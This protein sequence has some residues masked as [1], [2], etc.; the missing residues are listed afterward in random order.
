[1]VLRVRGYPVGTPP[2]T[3]APLDESCN[4]TDHWMTTFNVWHFPVWQYSR[5]C[6]KECPIYNSMLRDSKGEH[7][8]VYEQQFFIPVCDEGGREQLIRTNQNGDSEQE[9]ILI[10]NNGYVGPGGYVVDDRFAGPCESDGEEEYVWIE[11]SLEDDEEHGSVE[12][13]GAAEARGTARAGQGRPSG[14]AGGTL[15]GTSSRGYKSEGRGGGAGTAAA[16]HPPEANR[17]PKVERRASCM[18]IATHPPVA[19]QFTNATSLPDAALSQS[20]TSSPEELPEAKPIPLGPQPSTGNRPLAVVAPV[21][22]DYNLAVPHA[23]HHRCHHPRRCHRRNSAVGD[24]NLTTTDNSRGRTDVNAT[25]TRDN[26]QWIEIITIR[27]AKEEVVGSV[28]GQRATVSGSASGRSATVPG[29]ASGRSA[30]GQSATVP[31]SAS[32][33]SV[34]GQSATVPGSA[35]GQ[36]TTVPRSASGQSTTVPGSASGQST[37]VPGSASGPS[38]TVPGSASGS[39][40]T[41]AGSASGRSASCQSATVSGSASGQSTTVSGSASGPSTTVPGSAS[42]PS[43]TVPGS[44]SGLSTTVPGSASGP[45]TTVP[46]SASGPSATIPGSASGPSAT[47][48]RNTNVPH[49]TLAG[50]A[51]GAGTNTVIRNANPTTVIRKANT[52]TVIRKASGTTAGNTSG[53]SAA[54]SEDSSAEDSSAEDS[55]AEDSSAEDSSAEDSSTEDSSAEDGSAEDGSAEDGSAED[56][57]AEDGSTEDGSAEDGSAEDGS[58]ED[59]SS[60]EDSSAEDSSTEEG[61]GQIVLCPQCFNLETFNKYF[62][63]IGP[64]TVTLRPGKRMI[65]VDDTK[66]SKCKRGNKRGDNSKRSNVTPTNTSY[67]KRQVI[68]TSVI[69]SPKGESSKRESISCERNKRGNLCLEDRVAKRKK[70]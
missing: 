14:G 24:G 42:G 41:V 28:S 56:G 48:P 64:G 38:A 30:S 52:T 39:S 50:N 46:G 69:V 23:G 62:Y 32:G 22:A 8:I 29:S 15:A 49:V 36:S 51:S 70:L 44:A 54:T 5:K 3:R 68:Y 57:S 11:V 17:S 10:T 67:K 58:A 65:E 37:T 6:V 55:S 35:S 40:A 61:K 4:G 33:R 13:D 63:F 12:A 25:A 16:R 66:G 18:H 43:T 20:N 2:R 19:N 9:E 27:A 60:A 26:S 21:N 47:I 45:S 53:Q 34:S 31:G 59:D 1:M 7:K